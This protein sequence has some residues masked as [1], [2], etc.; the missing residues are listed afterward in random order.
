MRDGKQIDY[1]NVSLPTVKKDDGTEILQRD[2]KVEA[3]ENNVP[4]LIQQTFLSTVSTVR[5]IWKSLIGLVT[6]ASG[7]EH[8]FLD[9]LA[10]LVYF[11]MIITV[12]LGVVNLLP[13]PALDGGRLIFLIV[14]AIRRKPIKAE[15]EAYVHAAGMVMFLIFMVVISIKDII[16]LFI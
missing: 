3:I 7:L 12:N 4:V 2:F 10:N 13:L 1:V 15:H 16:Q 9:G 6:T 11:M 8:S 5:M 14:E